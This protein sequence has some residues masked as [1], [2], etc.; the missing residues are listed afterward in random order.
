MSISKKSRDYHVEKL[1]AEAAKNEPA[2]YHG[3]NPAA[4]ML[5]KL[6]GLKGGK[7]RA[8]ALTPER[9]KQIAIAAAS[10]RW[11]TKNA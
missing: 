8:S 1:V 5:G 2:T 9:R 7:T 3:K 6:G 4:V 10:A 11:N